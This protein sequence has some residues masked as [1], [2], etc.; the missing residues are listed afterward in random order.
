M[1]KTTG[2]YLNLLRQFK[3]DHANE[4]GIV[5]IGIFGSVARGEQGH[6]SDVDIFYEG[7]SMGLKSL[8]G[9]PTTLE[10][11]FNAPVDVVRKHKNLRPKFIQTIEKEVIYV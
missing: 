9:L 5:R 8:V 11:L 1:M 7:D 6:D 3:Q 2:E 4:Y 10:K